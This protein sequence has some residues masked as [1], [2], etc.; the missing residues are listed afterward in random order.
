M[1]LLT[2]IGILSLFALTMVVTAGIWATY[3]A[4]VRGFQQLVIGLQSIDGRLVELN[5]K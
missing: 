4:V 3:W 1:E 2:V 5:R